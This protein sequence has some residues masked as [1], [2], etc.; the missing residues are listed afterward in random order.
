MDKTL[1]ESDED[2]MN[3]GVKY[4]KNIMQWLHA[5]SF[6][7]N[8]AIQHTEYTGGFWTFYE[9]SNGAFFMVPQQAEKFTWSNPDNY[10]EGEVSA[11][12]LGIIACLFAFS[13]MSFAYRDND[14]FGNQYHKLREWSYRHPEAA[15]ISRAID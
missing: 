5:E 9:T 8:T 1:I 3:A 6:I 14:T 2:R 10:S 4:F 13:N 7:F 11:E 15:M 12:A